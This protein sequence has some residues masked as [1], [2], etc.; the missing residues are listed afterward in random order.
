MAVFSIR[1]VCIKGG[2]ST[3]S[4]I[5]RVEFRT[6]ISRETVKNFGGRR[7]DATKDLKLS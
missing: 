4:N 1:T 6:P 5:R 3:R 7:F 2:E